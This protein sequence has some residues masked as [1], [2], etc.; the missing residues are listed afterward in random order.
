[1][2]PYWLTLLLAFPAFH[3]PPAAPAEYI[4]ITHMG[5]ETYPLKTLI[6][7]PRR[8]HAVLPECDDLPRTGPRARQPPTALQRQLAQEMRCDFVL[9]DRFTYAAVGGF[10]LEHPAYFTAAGRPWGTLDVEYSITVRGQ[11]YGC[12]LTKWQLFT[13]LSAHLQSQQ[14]DK[15]LVKRIPSS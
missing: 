1:M 9:T 3:R 14:G 11:V 13:L 8:L 12:Y 6:L 15:A 5:A 10:V 7:S 4:A 2:N